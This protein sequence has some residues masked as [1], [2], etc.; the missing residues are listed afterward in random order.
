MFRDEDTVARFGGDEFIIVIESFGSQAAL[1]LIAK[2]LIKEVSTPL[3]IDSKEIIVSTSIGIAVAPSGGTDAKTLLR[4][5]DK[6]MYQARPWGGI[7]IISREPLINSLK[8]HLP[9]CCQA[10]N[11]HLLR[12]NSVFSPVRALQLLA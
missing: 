2:K 8:R 6:A 3:S 5:A 7:D 12:V 11:T 4:S 9:R 1:E 10:Q